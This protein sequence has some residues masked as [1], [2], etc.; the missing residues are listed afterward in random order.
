MKFG[1]DHF[2]TKITAKSL[3]VHELLK[4]KQL[5]NVPTLSNCWY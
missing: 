3:T 1:L 2:Q 5:L 4:L